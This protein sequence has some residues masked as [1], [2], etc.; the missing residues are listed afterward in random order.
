AVIQLT[1]P[2]RSKVRRPA[3]GP[4]QGTVAAPVV[5]GVT[6]PGSILEPL[7]PA[8]IVGTQRVTIHRT[9]VSSARAGPSWSMGRATR[10][11]MLDLRLRQSRSQR[12]H[13][14]GGDPA[15]VEDQPPEARQSPQVD[16][17]R[18]ADSLVIGEAQL[19]EIG[20]PFEAHQPLIGHLC[21]G[22]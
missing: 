13:P 12:T 2:S 17:A 6:L 18:V 11:S 20:Q 4:R 21:P 9:V 15:V 10:G 7:A 14:T 5:A 8:A 3:A 1:R 22:K 16:Q 19:P